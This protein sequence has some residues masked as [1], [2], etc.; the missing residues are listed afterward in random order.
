MNAI[1]KILRLNKHDYPILKYFYFWSHIAVRLIRERHWQKKSQILK[2]NNV[3]IKPE[4]KITAIEGLPIRRIT[5]KTYYFCFKIET[6][7]T[8]VLLFVIIVTTINRP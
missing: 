2:H 8:I 3:N 5:F 1:R 6:T 7:E 4:M